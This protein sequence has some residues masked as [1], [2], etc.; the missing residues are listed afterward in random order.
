[1]VEAAGVAGWAGANLMTGHEPCAALVPMQGMVHDGPRVAALYSVPASSEA[2]GGGALR[3]GDFR[4]TG[5]AT[6]S[7][8]A[9]AFL[10]ATG[11]LGAMKTCDPR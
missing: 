5:L 3:P 10:A 4:L 6:S 9:G 7:F 2:R 1:M 8:V 11:L